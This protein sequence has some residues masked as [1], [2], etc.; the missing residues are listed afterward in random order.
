VIIGFI[1]GIV[2]MLL[3]FNFSGM[4]LI[5]NS[6]LATIVGGGIGF[7][8]GVGAD[9]FKRSYTRPIININ[10]DTREVGFDLKTYLEPEGVVMRSQER[11]RYIGTRIKVENKGASAAED[12]KA[13]LIIE[14]T[15]LRVGWM[16]HKE[17][18][19]V[20]INAH[21]VEYL[22]LCAVREDGTDRI[23]ANEGGY[24]DNVVNASRLGAGTINAKLKVSAKNAEQCVKS[25]TIFDRPDLQNKLARLAG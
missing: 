12:C 17:D 18:G 2:V 15:E 19:T 9:W 21:D 14:E 25:I 20:I 22:D 5:S 3:A 7:L 4:P 16:M 10:E 6:I 24:A 1:S 8:S 13:T 11:T 23:F